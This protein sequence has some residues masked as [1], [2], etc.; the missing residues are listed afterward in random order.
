MGQAIWEAIQPIVITIVKDL[1][2][3]ITALLLILYGLFK[4]KILAFIK[5]EM[6]H[7]V[8]A[9]GFSLAEAQFKSESGKA[10]MNAA[11]VYVSEKLGKIHIKVTKEEIEAAIEKVVL[12]YNQKQKKVS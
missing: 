10:K 1:I 6:L 8:A 11:Y 7:K 9:E 12:E 2:G 5:N 4:T 3:W